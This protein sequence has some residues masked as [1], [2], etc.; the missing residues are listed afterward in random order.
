[1]GSEMCIRDS[2]VIQGDQLVGQ[3]VRA[4]SVAP[5]APPS[6]SSIPAAKQEGFI[7]EAWGTAHTVDAGHVPRASWMLRLHLHRRAENEPLQDLCRDISRLIQLAYPGEGGRFVS[8]VG[9]D[10]FVTALNDRELAYEVLKLEPKT[11][12]EPANHAMRL[13]A[14]ACSVDARTYVSASRVGGQGQIRPRNIFAVTDE[15]EEQ[16]EMLNSCSAL[17]N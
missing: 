4:P 9:V 16:G 5:G 7:A 13:D 10:T 3:W 17:H 2:P 11:L 1:M 6:S 14:L 12:E 8:L 15:K